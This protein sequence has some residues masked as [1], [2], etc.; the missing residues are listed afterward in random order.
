MRCRSAVLFS[1][2][3]N[4]DEYSELDDIVNHTQHTGSRDDLFTGPSAIKYLVL[5][6]ASWLSIDSKSCTNLGWMY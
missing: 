2:L 6:A 4:E 5:L 3:V 1:S